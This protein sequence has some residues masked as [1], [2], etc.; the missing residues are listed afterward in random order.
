MMLIDEGDRWINTALDDLPEPGLL[1][2]PTEFGLAIPF[3]GN[4]V[5]SY[6]SSRNQILATVLALLAVLVVALR[7]AE[8]PSP[9]LA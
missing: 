5:D 3:G 8:G 1:V 7:R 6:A 4:G 9:G 2:D